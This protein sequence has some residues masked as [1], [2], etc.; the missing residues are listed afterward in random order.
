[1]EDYSIEVHHVTRVEGHGNILLDVA[2]GK[3]KQLR[4]EIV[5]SPRF[6]EAMLLGRKWHEAQ[7]ISCRICAICSTAHSSASVRASEA[8][9]GLEPSEQTILLRRLAY[10]GEMLE[11]H[12]LH[13]LYLVLPDLLGVGS[14]IP[15]AESHPDE[16][17]IALRLKR[18]AN[19]LVEVVG[20][21]HIHACNWVPGGFHD[22]P[23]EPDLAALRERCVAARDDVA[24]CVELFAGLEFPDLERETEYLA[25]YH[26]DHYGFYDGTHLKSSKGDMTLNAD[27]L[28][29]V[30]EFVVPHSHAKHAQTESGPYAVG[31]LARLNVN[32][33]QLHPAAQEA[34]GRLGLRVPCCR[35]F[36]NNH[37]QLVECAH[38]IEEAI[39]LIDQLVERGIQEEIPRGGV[40]AGRGVGISEAPRGV[41]IHDYTYDREGVITNAN[42]VIPTAQNLN[43]LECDLHALV[44][45]ILD[46]PQEEIR[47]TME[48]LVRAYDPCIS[49]ATHLLEVEFV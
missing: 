30:R 44:P 45:R 49:C 48:M 25:L 6:F 5:E 11:S 22:Q 41:L 10:D 38:A 39:E 28:Q 27:Y 32:F 23:K 3:I 42:L 17:R 15:L 7:E 33:D 29:K 40:R 12:I 24:A 43:N 8:A 18:L 1:M 31:A 19:D 14:V 21:R 13:V 16:I 47:L 9:M 20:G 26:P 4:L 37:A 46:R 36:M 2:Q 35:P 34:A